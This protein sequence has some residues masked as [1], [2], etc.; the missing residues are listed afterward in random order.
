MTSSVT[1]LCCR[2]AGE[3]MQSV[4]STYY[5]VHIGVC[6]L[7]RHCYTLMRM[8]QISFTEF[9]SL[10]THPLKENGE[11]IAVTKDNRKGK[12]SGR[13]CVLAFDFLDFDFM[14]RYVLEHV[15]I[16]HALYRCVLV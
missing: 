15:C 6:T 8:F 11:Q 12:L 16:A 4:S 9:G 1:V 13:H 10:K 2:N 14:Y 7:Y 5:T 3:T